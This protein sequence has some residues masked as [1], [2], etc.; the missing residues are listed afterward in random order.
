MAFSVLAVQAG[1]HQVIGDLLPSIRVRELAN[2][3]PNIKL[4]CIY[5]TA[6]EP[7]DPEGYYTFC[8][9]FHMRQKSAVLQSNTNLRQALR[10]VLRETSGRKGRHRLSLLY[11]LWVLL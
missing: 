6:N 3:Q 9:A 10:V 7:V 2:P 4:T 11:V 1:S 8:N 5:E